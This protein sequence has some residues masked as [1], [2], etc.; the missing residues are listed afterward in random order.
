[1]KFRRTLGAARADTVTLTAQFHGCCDIHGN[2]SAG[3]AIFPEFGLQ[4]S[5][6]YQVTTVELASGASALSRRPLTRPVV[7]SYTPSSPSPLSSPLHEIT[8]T[9]SSHYWVR[10]SQS[11]LPL[12]LLLVLSPSLMVSPLLYEVGR[13]QRPYQKRAV[14]LRLRPSSYMQGNCPVTIRSYLIWPPT[15]I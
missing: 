7:S 14:L 4:P 10:V 6:I 1:M 8:L 15:N 3:L 5:E 12:H 2:G 11:S 9:L 13:R